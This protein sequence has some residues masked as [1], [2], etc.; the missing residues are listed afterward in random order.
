MNWRMWQFE[1][2]KMKAG[3]FIFLLIKIA[4]I[5]KLAHYQISTLSAQNYPQNYFRYPLDSLPNFV[6]PFGGLR[7]NHFHSGVDLKTNEREGFPVLAS[8][9]GFV[10][11]IKI[12]STAYGKAIYLKHP[13]GYT[14]VYGHL[15]KYH[16][17]IAQWIHAY[18]YKNESFE[19]DKVFE[20]PIL[21]VKKGDTIGFSGNSGGSTGPHLHFEI[22]DNKTEEIINPALFGILPFDTIKP[23]F[24]KICFYNFSVDKSFIVSE[25]DLNENKILNNDSVWIYKDTIEIGN[26]LN[27]LGIEAFDYIHNYKDEKTIYTFGL[28]LDTKNIFNFKLNKFA[29]DETKY[30]NTHIDYAYYK[31]Q[32][33]RI[34]KCFLEDGNEIKLYLHDK[35]K[36]K[37]LLHDF[38]THQLLFN[39]ADFSG[40][41]KKLIVYIKK[42]K[43][44][45]KL[46]NTN[47]AKIFYPNNH[48]ALA[49]KDIKISIAPNSFYDTVYFDFEILNGTKKSFSKIYKIHNSLTPLHKN[50][51]ISIKATSVKKEYQSKLLLAY[52]DK[53]EKH[54]RSA[55]G[56]FEKGWVSAKASSFGNYFV[57]I[58]TIS[59]SIEQVFIHDKKV[60]LDSLAW[61]I[62]MKDN[63]SGIAKYAAYLNNNWILMDYDAKNNLMSYKFDEIYDQIVLSKQK[64]ELKIVVTDRKGNKSSK[65]F[66]P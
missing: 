27:A 51:E 23:V 15:Q 38:N 54:F 49:K 1:N 55:G 19:F 34:Q 20:I 2:L 65:I 3:K 64:L 33:T 24:K 30:I 39:V 63:F 50:F 6:S 10:S 35:N 32:Q 62:E 60:V 21:L 53:N 37:F 9:D 52:F 29:F 11:R 26:G 66:Y 36:G 31:L 17:K 45:I 13:N 40:N 48:N 59:P 18:Q 7:D 43:D 47:T 44:L 25:F 58:D 46:Q 28:T 12:Q 14:T 5:F 57:T 42:K 56:N 41:Y 22:R 8:A 61:H 4:L 16:N